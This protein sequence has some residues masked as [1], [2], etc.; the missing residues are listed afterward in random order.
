MTVVQRSDTLAACPLA[1]PRVDEASASG[2]EASPGPLPGRR[3]HRSGRV[4]HGEPEGER[5]P[6]R[7]RAIHPDLAAVR[8]GDTLHDG[9]PQPPPLLPRRPR[10]T[11]PLE[12]LEDG[13]LLLGRERVSEVVD[14]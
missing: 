10:G 9:E 14:G 11:E 2:T 12:G 3:E 4:L 1:L 7:G 8:L 6:V 13:A 5:R